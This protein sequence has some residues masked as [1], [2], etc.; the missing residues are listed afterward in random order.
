MRISATLAA[1]ALL[2]LSFQ[3]CIFEDAVKEAIE[4]SAG[5]TEEDLGNL[6]E[7]QMPNCSKAVACCMFI[8]GQCGEVTLFTPPEEV[9]QACEANEAVLSEV[10]QEY[11]GLTE[12]D[13]PS[14]LADNACA[15]GL[16]QTKE[17]YREAV[18]QGKVDKAAAGAPSCKL[19]IEETV[20]PLNEGLGTQASYLP[21][22][23]ENVA[24]S[25]SETPEDVTEPPA[26]DQ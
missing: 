1:A 16:E 5:C 20:V 15:E 12:G 23:C 4:E 19:I 17:N 22:A 8:R 2:A 7:P 21:T 10:I 11:Q 13:C 9:V 18:D 14:Y 25:V 24:G 3:A 6:N 26:A